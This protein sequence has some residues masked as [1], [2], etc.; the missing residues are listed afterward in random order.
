MLYI[1]W[2]LFTVINYVIKKK[3]KQCITN[4][5]KTN[6]SYTR[7]GNPIHEHTTLDKQNRIVVL[8]SIYNMFISLKECCV[9]VSFIIR[10]EATAV[11]IYYNTASAL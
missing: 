5:K 6:V 7:K 10:S 1:Y 11:T 4:I 8:M 9:W 2:L 3:K